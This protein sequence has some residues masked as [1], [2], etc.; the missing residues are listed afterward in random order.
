MNLQ[1]Q[2]CL[3]PFPGAMGPMGSMGSMGSMGPA[4]AEVPR[5]SW[6]IYTLMV[7]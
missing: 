3:R 5:R 7:W 1:S 2:L 4:P 6:I